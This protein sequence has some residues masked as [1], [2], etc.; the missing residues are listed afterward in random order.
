VG[1]ANNLTLLR[2]VLIPVFVAL[3]LSGHGSWALG[4]FVLA[5]LTDT[6]GAVLDPAA[7]KLLM[8]AAFLS[9]ALMGRVPAW[10]VVLVM[11]RDLLL[12]LG[13]AFV[14]VTGG[15]VYPHPTLLGKATTLF[16]MGTVLVALLASLIRI[17][18]AFWTSLLLATAGL[19][20]ASGVQYLFLGRSLL[21]PSRRS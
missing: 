18:Q 13:T 19:T 6:L 5:G 11:G 1:L 12:I 4:V 8:A 14:H 21:S 9:L 20:V 15:Q 16:Q 17:P 7:D 3:L 2:I 10:I